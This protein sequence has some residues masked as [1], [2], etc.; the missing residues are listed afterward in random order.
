M[1]MEKP[2]Y[3][4][5]TAANRNAPCTCGSGR[6]LKACCGAPQQAN[7]FR[8]WRDEQQ[9][10]AI[11]KKRLER[12]ARYKENPQARMSDARAAALIGGMLGLGMMGSYGTGRRRF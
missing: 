2:I 9:R 5:P 7:A 8:D 10:A 12:E 4:K 1:F 11:E 6:K 3:I